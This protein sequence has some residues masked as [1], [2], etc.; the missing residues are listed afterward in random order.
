MKKWREF[1]GGGNGDG[2]FLQ[3]GKHPHRAERVRSR[4]GKEQSRK[5]RAGKEQSRKSR[6]EEQSRA[7]HEKSSKAPHRYIY[8]PLEIISIVRCCPIQI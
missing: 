7:A 6:S 5:S 1:L 8:F 4:A 2:F 3:K